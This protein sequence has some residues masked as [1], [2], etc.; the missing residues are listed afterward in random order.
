MKR[1]L[2]LALVLVVVGALAF[3]AGQADEADGT[4][5]PV[6]IRLATQSDQAEHFQSHAQSFMEANP[7]VTIE[8]D[9]AGD[10]GAFK[11]TAP[12]LFASSDS[13]DVSYYW[14]EPQS[15]YPVLLRAD[16][17]LPLDDIYEEHNLAEVLPA[18]IHDFYENFGHDDGSYYAVP[19]GGVYFPVIYYNRSIFEEVGIEAPDGS[20]PTVDEFLDMATRLREAGYEP[21]TAGL[22][23][24]WIVGHVNDVIFQRMVPEEIINDL[25]NNWFEGAEAEYSYTHPEVVEAYQTLNDWFDEVFAEG[26]LSRSYAEGRSLFIQERAAMYS[27]GSWGAASIRAEAGEDFDFGWFMYPQVEEDIQPQMLAYYGDAILIPRR[28]NHP[29]VAMDFVS[30]VMSLEQQRVSVEEFGF[31]SARGDIDPGFMESALGYPVSSMWQ[32]ANS[33]GATTSIGNSVSSQLSSRSF[34]LLQDMLS[35][36]TT[37]EGVAEELDRIA[38]RSRAGR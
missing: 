21:L 5:Q 19:I 28:S 11:Q 27:D 36:R 15:G 32:A 20:Y 12:Q 13:P 38:E 24:G 29:E 30:H 22:L 17:L 25:K 2:T 1:I 3:A 14:A 4:D 9:V 8:V 16:E 35:G 10:V 6:T 34:A 31:V 26:S 23:E 7:N 18:G 37:A 33:Y